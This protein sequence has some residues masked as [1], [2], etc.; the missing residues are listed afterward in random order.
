MPGKT[1]GQLGLPSIP[2]S[3]A[4]KAG[5]AAEE[6]SAR[7]TRGRGAALVADAG[8]GVLTGIL[9]CCWWSVSRNLGYERAQGVREAPVPCADAGQA[10]CLP[11]L[12]GLP[13][14]T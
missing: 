8:M 13:C 11:A 10:W 7:S 5:E 2:E 12:H 9:Q 14:P 3:S 4:D 6:P 1:R